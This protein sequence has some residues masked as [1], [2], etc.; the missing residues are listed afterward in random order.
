[1]AISRLSG[2]AWGVKVEH[3]PGPKH[4]AVALLIEIIILGI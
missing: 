3:E 4:I 1:M 2:Q